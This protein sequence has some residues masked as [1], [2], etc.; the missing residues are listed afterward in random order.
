MNCSLFSLCFFFCSFP[1]SFVEPTTF[2]A[3]PIPCPQHKILKTQWIKPLSSNPMFMIFMQ[4]SFQAFSRKCVSFY[5]ACMFWFPVVWFATSLP[6]LVILHFTKHGCAS[7]GNS[8]FSV[9]FFI[10]SLHSL[11]SWSIKWDASRLSRNVE[12]RFF[13]SPLL[14]FHS[15]SCFSLVGPNFGPQMV[16]SCCCLYCVRRSPDHVYPSGGLS[17]DIVNCVKPVQ[18]SDPFRSP[19]MF[20]WPSVRLFCNTFKVEG[21]LL[22]TSMYRSGI[23]RDLPE[24]HGA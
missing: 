5:D 10:V 9:R 23:G 24:A 3:S 22:I 12:L 15:L 16:R 6:V 17:C 18:D 7:I 20:L 14:F 19:S 1:R 4:S 2:R 11:S 13:D 21:V 8:N